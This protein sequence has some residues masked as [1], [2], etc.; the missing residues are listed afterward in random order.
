M[1]RACV[2]PSCVVPYEVTLNI[3][4]PFAAH[5]G[6]SDLVTDARKPPVISALRESKPQYMAVASDVR[7][8]KVTIVKGLT[9]GAVH[10]SQVVCNLGRC[11]LCET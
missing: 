4:V 10:L 11:R 7:R 2:F 3:V 6:H 1:P 5:V 8:L 9:G